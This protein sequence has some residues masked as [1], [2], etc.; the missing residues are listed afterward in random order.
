MINITTA[1]K[2]G[3]NKVQFAIILLGNS[4]RKPCAAHE[5]WPKT[6]IWLNVMWMSG[7][8]H[9]QASE[10]L[11]SAYFNMSGFALPNFRQ[12]NLGHPGLSMHASDP[13]DEEIQNHPKKISYHH[14]VTPSMIDFLF[15]HKG[16]VSRQSR[17][18]LSGITLP[19]PIYGFGKY[20]CIQYKEKR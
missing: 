7:G 6:Q 9:I 1:L 17:P 18:I 8:K 16:S 11:K 14:N 19:H 3:Y 5:S 10:T 4:G 12:G 13:C 15:R 2:P 20:K